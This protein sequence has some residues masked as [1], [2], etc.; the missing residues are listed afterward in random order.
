MIRRTFVTLALLVAVHGLAACASPTSGTQPTAVGGTIS[1][2][3]TV[4]PTPSARNLSLAELKYRLIDQFGIFYC[5]PDYYPVARAD[6]K[7]RALARFP[8]IESQAETFQAI[9][10]HTQLAGVPNLSADQKLVVYREFKKLNALN[11]EVSGD[12]YQFK[13]R[14]TEGQAGVALDGTIT[15]QGAVTIAKKEPSIN[16]CPICLSG[17]TMIDTP[18]GPIA[19]KNLR[20]GM[21]VW[22][23]DV[24]GARVPALILRTVNVPVAAGHAMVHLRLDDGREL[25]ASPGHPTADGRLLGWLQVGDVLDGAR[26]VAAGRDTDTGTATY[27]L[28]P[29]GLTGFYWA[30]GILMASTLG[31]IK[32][33]VNSEQWAVSSGQWAVS[34][35]QWAVNSGQ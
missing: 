17:E 18:S 30:N 5:D 15:R 4:V 23:S 19:V 14:T 33:T 3:R 11:L 13:L 22:T 12:V 8:E 35:E 26:V 31:L 32:L 9:L 21:T 25:F 20:S 6:E 2:A 16:T 10:Q 28:L 7:E 24:S 34:S 29:S 1:P 27:D